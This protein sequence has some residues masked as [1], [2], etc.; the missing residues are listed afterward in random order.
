MLKQDDTRYRG[1][2]HHDR[3]LNLRSCETRSSRH[4]T[5]DK[6]ERQIYEWFFVKEKMQLMP[7]GNKELSQP[8]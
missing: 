5:V 7:K 3:E 6:L 4:H 1:I 8:Y 2:K